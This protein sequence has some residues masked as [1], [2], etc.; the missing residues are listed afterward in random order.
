MDMSGSRLEIRT[1]ICHSHELI[2][3]YN[4][5]NYVM[6]LIILI[7]H[8]DVSLCDGVFIYG[9]LWTVYYDM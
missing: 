2:K 7:I 3:M 1:S 8:K 6:K 9:K 5:S 4:L